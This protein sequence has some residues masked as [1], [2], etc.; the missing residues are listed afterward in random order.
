MKHILSTILLFG[1]FISVSQI[2]A[3]TVSLDSCRRMA[4]RTNKTLKIAEEAVHGAE[5]TKKAAT[6][7]YLPAI[8][9]SA[10]YMYNQHKTSLL[11]EDAKLPTMFFNPLTGKYEYDL[12][13]GP[14]LQP[15]KDP[16]TGSYI[17]EVVAVIPKDALTFDTRSVFAG[18]ITLTQPIFMGGEIKALNDIARATQEV[19]VASRNNIEQ[20]VI[21]NVDESY[22]TV[23][24]LK[25]KRKLAE[26]FVNVVDTL[27]YNV[28]AML[29]EGMATKADLLSVDVKL[30]EAR[31]M[32]TKVDNGLALSRMALAQACG[33]PID[34][35]MKLEDEESEG[36]GTELPDYSY[37]MEDVY[38]CRQ[39]LSALRKG[40]G[41]ME[42]QEK[43]ALGSML[44]KLGLVGAY[45]F[46][47]PN[48][49]DG[50]S[51]KIGGGFSIGAALTIPIWHWGGNYNKYR[52]AKSATT[53]QRL[54]L[55]DMEEK[56]ML[57]V[58]QAKFKFQEAFKTYD[59][60]MANMKSAEENLRC[61]EDGFKEGVLTTND[62]IMAQTGWLQANSEKI[63][64]EIG[65]RLCKVYLSKVLGTLGR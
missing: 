59:M 17:P 40:I 24:S 45:T 4:L 63:D 54:L 38:A 11:S 56:V 14:D 8:D 7:A 64:A 62:V 16:A 37:N 23:I 6:A 39:D 41:V 31:I 27:R 15:V 50:F 18:A 43:L 60:A 52:A 46:S 20:D 12:L 10:T 3:Q 19:L 2:N 28:N 49:I 1:G 47:T 61:A 42:G 57:Q 58:N 29:E 36:I 35:E 55:E 44:P 32:L 22:W 51:R 13:I 30:N 48:V 25:A 65:I 5:Y 34:T 53:A 33:L 9:A 26:S 21:Y